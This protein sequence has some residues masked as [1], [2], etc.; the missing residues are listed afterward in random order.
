MNKITISKQKVLLICAILSTFMPSFFSRAVIWSRV[1]TLVQ[2]IGFLVF[3]YKFIKRGVKHNKGSILIIFVQLVFLMSTII[4]SGD[5]HRC[6]RSAMGIVTVV[7]IVDYYSTDLMNV[8]KPLY[9]LLELYVYLN[10][11]A[12]LFSPN[13][14]YSNADLAYGNTHLWI[15]GSGNYNIFWILPTLM[16]GWLLYYSNKKKY[17]VRVIALTLI[18]LATEVIQGSSTG[19][20][21]A[22]LFVILIGVPFIKEYL[23]PKL[24]LTFGIVLFLCV[25][26]FRTYNIFEF[27]I[28]GILKKDMTFSTRLWIW[29]NAIKAIKENI[30]IGYGLQFSEDTASL[31]GKMAGGVGW[32]GA[33]HCHCNY[34]QIMYVGGILAGISNIYIYYLGFKNCAF[35]FKTNPLNRVLTY[36]LFCYLIIG[37]T[38]QLEYVPMYIVL[39]LPCYARDFS[40]YYIAQ[41]RGEKR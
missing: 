13:G 40:R 19:L 41:K 3:L 12:V 17:K 20:V 5:I 30:F 18:A 25:V 27:L 23:T 6:I 32:A 34:L 31:L 21:G 29:D 24:A 11:F 39:C 37:I 9:F 22:F 7:L 35:E 14:L 16:L 8:I 38:E 1:C 15:F 10:F 36:A 28:V 33:T 4:S 26:V 2:Y